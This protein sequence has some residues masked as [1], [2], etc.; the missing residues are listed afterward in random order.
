M[1]HELIDLKVDEVSL[2]DKGANR[3]RFIV[4]KHEDGGETVNPEENINIEAWLGA[5][6]IAKFLEKAATYNWLTAEWLE[7][8]KAFGPGGIPVPNQPHQPPV[9]PDAASTTEPTS[10]VTGE[11]PSDVSIA[12]KDTIA[13]LKTVGTRID[14]GAHTADVQA[15]VLIASEKFKNLAD[16][17]QSKQAADEEPEVAKSVDEKIEKLEQTINDLNEKLASKGIAPVR[18]SLEGQDGPSKKEDM[19]PSFQLPVVR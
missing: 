18:K 11:Q 7:L 15:A 14:Q 16:L 3:K 10:S 9:P 4:I 2:V 12:I 6:G 1:A 8:E 5:E 19:W 17:M 13:A